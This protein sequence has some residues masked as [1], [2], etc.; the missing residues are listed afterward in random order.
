MSGTFK[1]RIRSLIRSGLR[2]QK[3][4]SHSP[5][6]SATRPASTLQQRIS[7]PSSHPYCVPRSSS[8]S[9]GLQD[10]STK[11]G[12]SRDPNYVFSRRHSS[13]LPFTQSDQNFLPP[14][15]GRDLSHNDDDDDDADEDRN[16]HEDREKLSPIKT[17]ES[18]RYTAIS[19][20]AH[21]Y[22]VYKANGGKFSKTTGAGGGNSAK[23]KCLTGSSMRREKSDSSEDLI[24][25][26]T[27][28]SQN[29]PEPTF[30]NDVG[31]TETK[32][33]DV[34]ERKETKSEDQGS[35]G[36]VEDGNS[37]ADQQNAAD[38][39]KD[40]GREGTVERCQPKEEA[41]KKIQMCSSPKNN[42]SKE[43]DLDGNDDDHGVE[44]KGS[45]EE[46]K[47]MMSD[48]T[49][50]VDVYR[51]QEEA[52]VT[53]QLLWKGIRRYRKKTAKIAAL[54]KYIDQLNRETAELKRLHTQAN[55]AT[56][57]LLLEG[58]EVKNAMAAVCDVTV[59]TIRK[60]TQAQKLEP[61]CYR[62]YINLRTAA[63]ATNVLTAIR[64]RQRALSDLEVLVYR[65]QLVLHH[66]LPCQEVEKTPSK[67]MKSTKASKRKE[68]DQEP[69][70][71]PKDTRCVTLEI[72]SA[73]A[74]PVAV[75]QESVSWSNLVS[76]SD[77]TPTL[78]VAL[79][80]SNDVTGP[81]EN[82]GDEQG[83]EV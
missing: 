70:L 33:S 3:T 20:I 37:G 8:T 54:Q 63:D 12:C 48:E 6:P 77:S 49:G 58:R 44:N 34:A 80:G 53:G 18:A 79:S 41:S 23:L 30:H 11:A 71:L 60:E 74:T 28:C 82:E 78:S 32:Q 56:R 67:K 31:Y 7:H 65:K 61:L 66:S 19:P 9:E 15:S 40:R 1:D 69:P 81:G 35:A 72:T 47:D 43:G 75:D 68:Q 64:N 2:R 14:C 26:V 29:I 13:T 22:E 4:V 55:R 83:T 5:P 42:A 52:S 27:I 17:P 10:P 38:T 62:R 57:A 16:D 21:F 39:L 25:C 36:T 59:A 24:N 45:A 76:G 50:M 73:V 51:L 46:S